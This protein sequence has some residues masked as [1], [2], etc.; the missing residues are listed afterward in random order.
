MAEIHLEPGK[1]SLSAGSACADSSFSVRHPTLSK[2]PENKFSTQLPDVEIHVRWC[3][4][5][6]VKILLPN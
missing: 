5:M 2:E 6:V 1:V 4:R 3:G